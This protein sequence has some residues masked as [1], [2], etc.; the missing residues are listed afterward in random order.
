M[1]HVS[2]LAKTYNIQYTMLHN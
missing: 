1:Q 2:S